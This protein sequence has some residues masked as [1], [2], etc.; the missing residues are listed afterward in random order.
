[1][2]PV[3]DQ[4]HQPPSGSSQMINSANSYSVVDHYHGN[5]LVTHNDPAELI[6]ECPPYFIDLLGELHRAASGMGVHFLVTGDP[7]SIPV[8]GPNVVAILYHDE[9]SQVPPYAD[10]VQAVFRGGTKNLQW[11]ENPLRCGFHL[12]LLKSLRLSRDKAL[13]VNRRL[14]LQARLTVPRNVFSIPIGP[15]SREAQNPSPEIGLRSIDLSLFGAIGLPEGA[16][17]PVFAY[18][19]KLLLRQEAYK[20]LA[21]LRE[22]SSHLKVSMGCSDDPATYGSPLSLEKYAETLNQT[23]VSLC[24]GGNFMETHRH[25]ESARSGCVI[26]S[27]A[28]PKEWYYEQHPF[29]L[30]DQWRDLPK[31]TKALFADPALLKEK[32]HQAKQWWDEK[33]SPVAVAK[34]ILTTL[35]SGSK[36]GL[37][38]WKG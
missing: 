15:K 22:S 25:F 36:N 33:I 24:P 5:V 4:M 31:I 8:T 11:P 35:R 17:A 12:A 9:R 16:R 18:R 3:T 14:R 23:K 7:S 10:H 13:R 26:L 27:E 37:P 30:I 28:P 38:P 20:A 1:M 21:A 19:P 6:D 32:S 34:Y 2:L 29:V